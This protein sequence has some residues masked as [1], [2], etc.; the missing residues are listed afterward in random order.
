MDGKSSIIDSILYKWKLR[1][2]EGRIYTML[3]PHV[4][5]LMPCHRQTDALSKKGLALNADCSGG[6]GDF[7]EQA[8]LLV[9]EALTR[10][11]PGPVSSCAT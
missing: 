4:H 11:Q 1:L 8:A 2:R 3:V 10:K 9:Q 6:E 5:K 7:G